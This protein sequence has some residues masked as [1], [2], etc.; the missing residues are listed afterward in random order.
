M[1]VT[2][3]SPQNDKPTPIM[4]RLA[5]L[6]AL[7]S[8]AGFAHA[9]L[10]PGDSLTP[11]EIKNVENGKEYCQ[12]C[13]YTGKAAKVVAFGKLKDENFWAD[14]KKLQKLQSGYNRLGVF[15]QIIDSKDAKA[16]IAAAKK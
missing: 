11:Y 3:S 1:P 6:L 12:V 2:K 4:K 8:A 13:A 16:I 5:T 7:L 15:D 9:G 14:L 10:K